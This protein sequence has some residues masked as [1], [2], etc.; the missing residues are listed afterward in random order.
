MLAIDRL[1][2]I[3]TG[4]RRLST[5]ERRSSQELLEPPSSYPTPKWLQGEQGAPPSSP[6]L[7]PHYSP[8]DLFSKPKRSP[9]GES[10]PSLGSFSGGQGGSKSNL[11]YQPDVV[12]IQVNRPSPARSQ[13]QDESVL[14]VQNYNFQSSFHGPS[15]E[16]GGREFDDGDK[17]GMSSSDEM[18]GSS[19]L[20]RPSAIV[21]PRISSRPAKPIA[22]IIAK[23][24]RTSRDVTSEVIKVE[25]PNVD[26]LIV[27]QSYS[28]T[29]GRKSS[30]TKSE[31]IYD[32]PS[33]TEVSS[34]PPALHQSPVGSR[35][36]SAGS[37]PAGTPQHYAVSPMAR[38]GSGGGGTPT[39]PGGVSRKAP[40][41]PPKR[42]NSIKNDGGPP[43][44]ADR[45]G[46]S[47]KED[48]YA[49]GGP[50]SSPAAQQQQT[51]A[52]ATCVK[53][54]TDRFQ[55]PPG[56]KQQ[57]QQQQQHHPQQPAQA[58]RPGQSV[59]PPPPVAM[60]PT[61]QALDTRAKDDG[62]RDSSSSDI[63]LP[64][65]PNSYTPPQE[66]DFPPPP[67]PISAPTPTRPAPGNNPL[68]EVIERLERQGGSPTAGFTG[69]RNES[70]SSLD[71]TTSVS[72]TDLNTLPFA[73][74]NVGT[75]K[76]R[77]PST[78]PSIVSVSSGEDN[79]ERNV[80]LNQSMFEDNTGT[81]KRKPNS[82]SSSS[83]ASA[84]QPMAQV[85]PLLRGE[86]VKIFTC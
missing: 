31:P 21:N 61:Q 45:T 74:E 6:G 59:K 13:S 52:F 41:P 67:P 18:D 75:I 80:E 55:D 76:Q 1:K 10:L 83:S 27:G 36:G 71:S 72:S 42:T 51:P 77:N 79:A 44:V 7:P 2:R 46:G 50:P 30:F 84:A 37:T 24:K 28:G 26:D 58:P 69:K 47:A 78:K 66:E 65:A 4:S 56:G 64:E 86:P 34:T 8:Q 63:S 48:P 33:S 29:L 20:K 3:Q 57:Y 53:S 49:K 19:T 39:G 82:S 68:T 81:I 15:G 32:T 12:A 14:P 35:S 54:L 40:P 62:R 85:Q 70:S 60:R 9:S 43:F 5:L 17:G 23:T 11:V 22:K 73:N 25:S 16:G 38:P